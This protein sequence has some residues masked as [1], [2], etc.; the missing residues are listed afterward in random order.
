[1]REEFSDA[2]DVLLGFLVFVVIPFIL[3]GVS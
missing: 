2:K 3:W 1:M